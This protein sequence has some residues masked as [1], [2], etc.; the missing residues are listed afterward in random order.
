MLVSQLFAGNATS[1]QV[2]VRLVEERWS[3]D[4]LTLVLERLHAKQVDALGR[5]AG[6][7]AGFQ[8]GSANN[9]AEP[10][11]EEWKRLDALIESLIEAASYLDDQSIGNV[12]VNQRW[13]GRVASSLRSR[14]KE[15]RRTDELEFQRKVAASVNAAV[16][17]NISVQEYMSGTLGT[18]VMV[19]IEDKNGKSL[20]ISLIMEKVARVPMWIPSSLLPFLVVSR[21][22]LESEDVKTIRD[23]V[24][25]GTS[26]Y[27]TSTDSIPGGSHL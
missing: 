14:L 19:D 6:S 1:V 22:R 5:N 13:T 8:I 15:L 27:V 18:T 23:D 11:E 12:N 17:S 4:Q 2:S 10:D 24:L 21:N 20:N 25:S 3:P 26:F 16:N 7:P 9:R